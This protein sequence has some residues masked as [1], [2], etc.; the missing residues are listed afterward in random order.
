MDDLLVGYLIDALDPPNRRAVEERLRTDPDARRKL[1]RL[2][3]ALAPLASDRAA[4]E[5]PSGLVARTLARIAAVAPAVAPRGPRRIGPDVTLVDREAGFPTT[6][7]RR[8]DALVA[9][10]VLVVLGGLGV[11]G[12]AHVQ[13]QHERLACQNNLRAI[14][15]GLLV[16]ADTH[17]GTFPRVSDQPP[18]N[19]A[20]AFVPL[21]TQAGV[22]T[23]VSV[24]ACPVVLS[25]NG[26]AVGPLPPGLNPGTVYSY[27]LGYRDADGR[28][29]GLRA[30]GGPADT[31]LLPIAADLPAP[32]SHG[33]GQN[34]L[35]VGGH[36]RF[37]T[38]SRVGVAGD[39]IYQNQ[40]A[41][42]A[43]GLHRLDTA[44]GAGDTC[45]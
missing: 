37:C 45:P 8:L 5:P 12:V 26:P 35:Y 23:D 28:L 14:G 36:V 18:F 3:G 25:A 15:D 43:A 11:S 39:D 16:Y 10:C 33:V 41:R 13:R 38:S 31:D 24:A 20:A 40:A 21:L 17:Q 22:L 7:W 19:R 42:I 34:V 32:V 2:R 9:A 27:S 6:R 30:D 29:H 1:E 4:D 44:L